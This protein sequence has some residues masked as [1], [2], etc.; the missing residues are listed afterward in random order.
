LTPDRLDEPATP[1]AQR[2]PV[3]GGSGHGLLLGRP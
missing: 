2:P 1:V 3:E